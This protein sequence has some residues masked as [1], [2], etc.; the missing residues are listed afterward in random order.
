MKSKE[1]GLTHESKMPLKDRIE[2]SQEFGEQYR[3][4][5]SG[6]DQRSNQEIENL[7]KMPKKDE[8]TKFGTSR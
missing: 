7:E 4:E 5:H 1:Q 2:E 8:D 3:S 6:Q